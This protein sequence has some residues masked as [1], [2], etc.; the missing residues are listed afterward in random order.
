MPEPG[1]PKLEEILEQYTP[2]QRAAP[3]KQYG[4]IEKRL[5]HMYDEDPKEAEKVFL[6]EVKEQQEIVNKQAAQSNG[7]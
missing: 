3:D 6:E 1:K 5:T 4:T 7:G 2:E